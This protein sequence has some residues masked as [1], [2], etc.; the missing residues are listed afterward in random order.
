[1][2]IECQVLDPTTRKYTLRMK[3][4]EKFGGII[5]ELED[6]EE[7]EVTLQLNSLEEAF[8]GILNDPELVVRP[9]GHDNSRI[10]IPLERSPV[11]K[12]RK[13]RASLLKNLFLLRRNPLK[14]LILYNLNLLFLMVGVVVANIFKHIT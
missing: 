8:M 7:I 10:I 12:S 14:S 4:E 3:D 2:A 9:S 13:F 6:V 1:M 5:K 11:V